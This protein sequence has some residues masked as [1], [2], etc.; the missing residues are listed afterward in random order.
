MKLSSWGN[1]TM[2]ELRARAQKTIS[3]ALAESNYQLDKERSAALTAIFKDA[4]KN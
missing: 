1:H 3:A 4:E 2:P